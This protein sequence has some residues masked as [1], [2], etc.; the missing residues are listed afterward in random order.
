MPTSTALVVDLPATAETGAPAV[1][2]DRAAEAMR[3]ACPVQGAVHF[4]FG[5]ILLH[6][7]LHQPPQAGHST[8]DSPCWNWMR[9]IDMMVALG[10]EGVIVTRRRRKSRDSGLRIRANQVE[11]WVGP[12]QSLNIGE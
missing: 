10:G 6:E 12:S 8:I 11:A 9:L 7:A 5:A 2:A 1:I 3:P 4:G